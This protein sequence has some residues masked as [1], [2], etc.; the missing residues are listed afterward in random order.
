[1]ILTVLLLAVVYTGHE[2]C[3]L[4]LF[5]NLLLL[6][7]LGSELRVEVGVALHGSQLRLGCHALRRCRSEATRP[8]STA[9]WW[10]AHHLFCGGS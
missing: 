10:T 6:V 4:L 1:M 7:V 5:V 3:L 9:P 2:L 8:S